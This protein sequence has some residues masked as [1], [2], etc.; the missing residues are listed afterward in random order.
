MS[1]PVWSE[2]ELMLLY[3]GESRAVVWRVRA[4]EREERRVGMMW[5][6]FAEKMQNKS[7][8]W[9]TCLLEIWTLMSAEQ[10]CIDYTL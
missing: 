8:V 4:R 6:V 2:W 7:Q 1:D 9:R 3:D 10:R 5:R